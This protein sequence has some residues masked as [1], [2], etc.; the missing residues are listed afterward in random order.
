MTVCCR[1]KFTICSVPLGIHCD[2][3]V[4]VADVENLNF[5]KDLRIVS[6]IGV[7]NQNEVI[8]LAK[9]SPKGLDFFQG[10]AKSIE[11]YFNH[12]EKKRLEK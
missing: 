6:H 4:D 8:N 7:V 1:A 11:E 2:V 5:E 3:L 10:F 12:K 9:K